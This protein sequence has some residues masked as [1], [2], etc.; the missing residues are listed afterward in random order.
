[1]WWNGRG[2][3]HK[4]YNKCCREMRSKLRQNES[5]DLQRP[6]IRKCL[7]FSTL[8][9]NPSKTIDHC[10]AS[11]Y[12]KSAFSTKFSSIVWNFTF[13]LKFTQNWSRGTK[14]IF[15][16]SRQ[17]SSNCRDSVM[18][19]LLEKIEIRVKWVEICIKHKKNNL[20]ASID[21]NLPQCA[22]YLLSI[23]W[24]L[25]FNTLNPLSSTI[26]LS[27]FISPWIFEVTTFND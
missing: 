1:M 25:Y 11:F 15:V 7:T 24:I 16:E 12:Q 26:L 14:W 8:H 19:T 23:D 6:K 10:F 18:C 9:R 27:V 2:L 17:V 5:F 21:R 3:S 22:S 13:L 4:L 20:L